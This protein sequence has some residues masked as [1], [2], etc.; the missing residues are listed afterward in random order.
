MVHARVP[1]DGKCTPGPNQLLHSVAI[2]LNSILPSFGRPRVDSEVKPLIGSCFLTF[3]PDGATCGQHELDRRFKASEDPDLFYFL[4]SRQLQD[5][6]LNLVLV[7]FTGYAIRKDTR[8]CAEFKTRPKY[9]PNFEMDDPWLTQERVRRK[10]SKVE[11]GS[12]V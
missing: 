12:R 1:G 7:L 2:P 4:L 10:D 8:K 11:I 3:S 9:T 6:Q 5:L